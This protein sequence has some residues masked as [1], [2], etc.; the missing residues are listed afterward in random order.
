MKESSNPIPV[1][2]VPLPL[3]SSILGQPMSGAAAPPREQIHLLRQIHKLL[4]GRYHWAAALGL[5]GL[6]IGATIGHFAL[7]VTYQSLGQIKIE[8]T[9]PVILVR[10]EQSNMLPMFEAY[11][12]AQVD[13]MKSRRVIQMAMAKEVW[14]SRRPDQSVEALKSFI[15][16]LD[17]V[18][19]KGSQ[20]INIGF[21]DPDPET[22]AA[23][24]QA[25]VDSYMDLRAEYDVESEKTR[26]EVLQSR[27]KTLTQQD[28]QINARIMDIAQTVGSPEIEPM[29]QDKIKDLNALESQLRAVQLELATSAPAAADESKVLGKANVDALQLAQVDPQTAQYLAEQ[30]RLATQIQV[31]RA[32]LGPNHRSVLDQQRSLDALEM[33][34]QQRA[35]EVRA[36]GEAGFSPATARISSDGLGTTTL[37][38]REG[39]TA[40]ERQLTQMVTALR[41][42]VQSLGDKNYR[43]QQ[44]KQQQETV[45]RDREETR[46][47]LEAL[48]VESAVGGRVNVISRGD[49]PLEP[50]NLSKRRQLTIIGGLFGGS[51]GVGFILL[52]GLLDR[53]LKTSD[54]ARYSFQQMRLLGI[55]PTLPDNLTDPEQASAAAFAVH[56]IRTM[57]QLSS[58]D[59]AHRIFAVTSPAPGTGKTSLSFAL[60]LSFAHCG[61]RTLLVDA[62]IIGAG[63]TFRSD[64]LVHPP[65]AEVL[66][67]HGYVSADDIRA[68]R[69]TTN[70]SDRLLA[71]TLLEQSLITPEALREAVAIQNRSLLGI[72]DVL[73]G[74]RPLE[75]C[76][77]HLGRNLYILPIG[78]AKTSQASSLSPRTVARL[79]EQARGLFDIVL[80]DT[81]PILGSIE[82]S[83]V[84]AHADSVVLTVSR[85]DD[86]P[87]TLRAAEHLTA[88]GARLAGLVFNRANERDVIRSSYSSMHSKRPG[89]ASTAPLLLPGRVAAADTRA[90]RLGPI[91]TA[92]AAES[93]A[94][95]TPASNE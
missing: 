42:E 89:A 11:M 29:Y 30:R 34:I 75:H 48:R 59:S 12:D 71:Q 56:H 78:S 4:R 9:L 66:E 79:L 23:A 14:K 25:V 50:A 90:R 22:S 15:R 80:L 54:D 3:D 20:T 27:L 60:G 55:L 53:R 5:A 58:P 52:L 73:Q 82:A 88:I 95:E 41:Q 68:A 76:L 63:L 45:R 6:I 65:L 51:T 87:L 93:G 83:V 1:Q 77:K 17:V 7:S 19:P 24:V 21:A 74:Q 64:A 85:G 57:I 13:M 39:L 31:L 32:K 47:R 37:A 91:A 10:T 40:R 46:Q 43:V 38:T 69:Q 35:A 81:G 62:D 36:L 86:R 67:A 26:L 94:E 72:L 16:N 18:H 28:E 44:L 2:A 92:V 61:L 33:M 49:R 70:G 84:A 8:P